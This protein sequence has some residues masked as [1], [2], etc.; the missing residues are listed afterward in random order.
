M[1]LEFFKCM[2]YFWSVVY[3]LL[4]VYER[5]AGGGGTAVIFFTHSL[6]YTYGKTVQVPGEILCTSTVVFSPG[7]V[8]C[9]CSSRLPGAR[10][11]N[12]ITVLRAHPTRQLRSL[13]FALELL[14]P[15]LPASHPPRSSRSRTL[16]R[17]LSLSLFQFATPQ[18]HF[19]RSPFFSERLPCSYSSINEIHKIGSFIEQKLQRLPHLNPPQKNHPKCQFYQHSKYRSCWTIPSQLFSPVRVHQFV[20]ATMTTWRRNVDNASLIRGGWMLRANPAA[21]IE[22]VS[23]HVEYCWFFLLPCPSTF[24]IS[25]QFSRP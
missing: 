1:G 3:I 12:Q 10:N 15:S 21:G 18:R 6:V 5:A 24:L 2:K 25:P 20:S 11:W 23:R 4:M 19:Y 8:F 9:F 14:E 16:S 7:I 22:I 13:A 17:F